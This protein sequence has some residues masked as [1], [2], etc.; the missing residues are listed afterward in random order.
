ML[1]ALM[2]SRM[3]AGEYSL[4]SGRVVGPY[5]ILEPLGEGG[6][7]V[8]FRAQRLE[9]PDE[10]IALKVLR[11]ELAGDEV[12]RQR[13]LREARAASEVAH[14]N[15]VSVLDAGEAA[16]RP[17]LAARYVAGGP[18]SARIEADGSLPVPYALRVVRDVAAGLDALHT[19]G[20]VHRDVKASNVM[21]DADG[22]ALITDFGLAKGRADTVLTRP[23][24][25]MG[26]LD[27]VAPE[28]IRGAEASPASDIYA[29]A[30]LAHECL[31]GQPPF[32]S[33]NALQVGVAHLEEEPPD[34]SEAREDIGPRLAW[35]VAQGLQKDPEKRLGTATA[36]ARLIVAATRSE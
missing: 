25:L 8:V 2:W 28:L 26:T 32:A 4:V 35:A 18:L 6:M 10:I 27:Y 29:L 12:Y 33:L 36:Y 17:Y 19:H 7:G 15:I 9:A 20:I 31:A 1:L 21:L 3:P 16:G 23:G 22:A 5:R 13:F 11:R 14:P 30:C 34:L 24:Q